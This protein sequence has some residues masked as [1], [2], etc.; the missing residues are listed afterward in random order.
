MKR[1]DAEL[2]RL[3][4]ALMDQCPF[5]DL[6]EAT[7]KRPYSSHAKSLKKNP[8]ATKFM[9]TPSNAFERLVTPS[10]AFRRL[11]SI[12]AVLVLSLRSGRHAMARCDDALL[13]SLAP[14]AANL[15]A[16]IHHHLRRRPSG[17]SDEHDP[18][19]AIATPGGGRAVDRML[20]AE[21]PNAGSLRAA[22][23]PADSCE[24]LRGHALSRLSPG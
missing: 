5:S 22:I 17:L 11:E 20:M 8:P 19:P 23:S 13:R 10:D 14:S 21:M 2:A 18:R 9:T 4:L 7:T 15:A 12:I 24:T 6:S 16:A 3:H 1:D